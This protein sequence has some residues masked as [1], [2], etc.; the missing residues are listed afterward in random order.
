M[1]RLTIDTRTGVDPTFAGTAGGVPF[2]TLWG[3]GS[4]FVAMGEGEDGSLVAVEGGTEPTELQEHFGAETLPRGGTRLPEGFMRDP[5]EGSRTFILSQGP[6]YIVLPGP[7]EGRRS[8]YFTRNGEFSIFFATFEAPTAHAMLQTLQDPQEF[9]RA[10]AMNLEF[11]APEPVRV[12]PDSPLLLPEE[13]AP[14]RRRSR[15]RRKA[16]L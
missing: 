2:L 4:L 16:V 3:G 14:I 9:G 1:F 11:R 6:Q 13:I 15:F 5:R 8:Y 10:F 7:E 12:V